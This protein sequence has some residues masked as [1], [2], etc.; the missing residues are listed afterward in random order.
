MKILGLIFR[1]SITIFGTGV[2][3]GVSILPSF[4]YGIASSV[5]CCATFSDGRG[6]CLNIAT[7]VPPVGN[8]HNF[9]ESGYYNVSL[10]CYMKYLEAESYDKK[11]VY[12]DTFPYCFAQNTFFDEAFKGNLTPAWTFVTD[13]FEV[14]STIQKTQSCLNYTPVYFWNIYKDGNLYKNQTQLPTTS[15]ILSLAA[16][17][18][19]PGIYKVT[20]NCSFSITGG[21]W[22]EDYLFLEFRMPNVKAIV[23]TQELVIPYIDTDSPFKFILDGTGSGDP[24]TRLPSVVSIPLNY[25]WTCKV[26]LGNYS[27]LA[28]RTFVLNYAQIQNDSSLGSSNNCG[29]NISQTK[30]VELP[31]KLLN[32][33]DKWYLFFLTVTRGTRNASAVQAVK[34][35]SGNPIMVM[36]NLV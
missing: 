28:V 1:N 25:S 19:E 23:A 32:K 14:T 2:N 16:E 21:T 11:A 13:P 36:I 26:Y 30:V 4:K 22:S 7:A 34:P 24:V 8:L 9:T 6:I 15:S 5:D 33:V 10:F 18:M 20:L 3:N 31:N 29:F 12:A 17:T 27:D 35:V